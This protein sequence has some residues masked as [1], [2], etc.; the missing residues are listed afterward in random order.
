MRGAKGQTDWLN[1]NDRATG[2]MYGLTLHHSDKHIIRA[3]M[4]GVL[5]RLYSIF[6]CM[7]DVGCDVQ[8]LKISG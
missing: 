4:E 5:Y 3:M 7:K 2:M 6:L 8:T 1:W